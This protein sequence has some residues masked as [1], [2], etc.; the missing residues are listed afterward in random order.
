M[1]MWKRTCFVGLGLMLTLGWSAS[2]EDAADDGA[3]PEPAPVQSMSALT[4]GPDGLLFVGDAKG[5][6]VFAIE[7]GDVEAGTVKA[8]FGIRDLE[9]RIAAMLGTRASEVLIHDLAVNPASHN[10]YLAVSRGRGRWESRWQLPNELADASMLLRITTEGDL[11]PVDLEG[12][13]WSKVDLPGPVDSAKEHRWKKGV[14]LR[15]DSITDL[16]YD[17]GEVW[18]AGLSNEEFAS[19]LWRVEYPFA[20]ASRTSVEIFHGAHGEWETHAPIRAFLPYRFG[21]KDHLL[22]AYLCTPLVTFKTASLVDGAHVKGRTVAEFGA[23]NYPLDMVLYKKG[24][25]DRL[26]IANSNL[27][28][29]IVDAADVAA[30]EGQIDTEV[31]GYTG[32][33]PYEIRSGS[34][35]QQLDLLDDA[36]VVGLQRLPGGTLDLITLPVAWL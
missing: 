22:A 4:F 19:A 23:G 2:A 8:R 17:D 28:L 27:P 11:E 3:A 7:T 18:V 34:G 35:V 5:A 32:G 33:V 24:D 12:M 9:T 31:E 1:S 36:T 21:D 6:A 15:T 30:F 10:I 14:P 25:A 13:A 20:G 16:V 29:M 26:L